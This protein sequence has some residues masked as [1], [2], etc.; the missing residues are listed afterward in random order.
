VDS[1]DTVMR[2]PSTSVHATME[3]RAGA[4]E[5]LVR[6]ILHATDFS[7]ASERAFAHALAIA[8]LRQTELTILHVSQE[9]SPDAEWASF[10]AV[11]QIL[12]RWGLLQPG[13]P[14]S[15]VFD[16][17]HVRVKKV[18][19]R[20]RHPVLATATFLTDQEPTDLVVLATEGRE[21]PRRWI[22]RSDAEAI[23]RWSRTMTLFVPAGAKRGLVSL[24]NGD[25]T[26]K[27]IVVPVDRHPDC[28]AAVEFARRAA[29]VLGEDAVTITL[30]HVGDSQPPSPALAE[31][32][33]WTWNKEHRSGEVV[34][35]ILS[36]ADRH[37]ADLIVMA[38]A[39]H[40]SVLDALRGSTTE[41]VVRRAPCP[42]LAVPAST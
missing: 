34:E 8:L 1:R 5:P 40:D 12:E 23:A 18:V 10:P 31:G 6:S 37:V 30:L 13:S 32:P 42:L 36:A 29:E 11:R 26:L 15:A 27:N 22:D 39:G 4:T 20:S 3:N 14:R 7:P 16:E 41:Q 19:L 24:D 21:G 2:V 9:K 25:L 38:T 17:L 28:S 33:R 35:E